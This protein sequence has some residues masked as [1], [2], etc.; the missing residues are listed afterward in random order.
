MDDGDPSIFYGGSWI[1]EGGFYEY[2]STTHKAAPGATASLQF[3]G[4][5]L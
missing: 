1:N 4:M 5:F 2:L 3:Y